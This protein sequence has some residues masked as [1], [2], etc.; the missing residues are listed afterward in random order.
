MYMLPEEY[1][2]IYSRLAQLFAEHH[3]K[4]K[5]KRSSVEDLRG[6]TGA[7]FEV[8]VAR[9]LK[10]NGW[11]VSGTPTTGDQGADLIAS[12]ENR[13]LIIQAKCYSGSVGNS[14]VQEVVGAMKF[15][16][17]TEGCVVTNSTFTP[18]ARALAQKTA[19]RLI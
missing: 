3:E 19:V 12:K 8:Y 11:S 10:E 14:A 15:Y 18:S 17:G 16:D 7:E 4:Q 1:R 9:L 13:K 2:W 6:L 5:S